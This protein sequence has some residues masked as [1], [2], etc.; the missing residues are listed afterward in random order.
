MPSFLFVLARFFLRV[1]A[2]LV[3]VIDARYFHRYGTNTLVKETT[4]QH[5][6]YTD[7]PTS[8]HPS[9]LTNPDLVASRLPVLKRTTVNIALS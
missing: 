5:C 1:D 2:V 6:R 7:L 4:Y 3:R 8:L 9:M